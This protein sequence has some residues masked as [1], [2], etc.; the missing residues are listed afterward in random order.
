TVR[1]DTSN[2]AA[3]L[4]HVIPP[5]THQ[6]IAARTSSGIARPRPPYLAPT[7]PTTTSPSGAVAFTT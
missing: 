5:S 3:V 4:G 6:R 2:L 1:A 7:L